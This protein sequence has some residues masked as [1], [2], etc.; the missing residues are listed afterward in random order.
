MTPAQL[1]AELAAGLDGPHA[2][3]DTTG[4]AWLA[5]EAVRFLNYATGSHAGQGLIFPATVYSVTGNLAEAAERLPQLF[6][7][8]TRW[9]DAEHAAARLGDDH[10]GPV[11]PLTDRARFHLDHAAY[12]AVTLSEELAAAQSALATVHAKRTEARP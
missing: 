3:E 5:A 9:L 12:H 1:A 2:D 10:G 6:G 7:Q 11:G 8:L 4:A